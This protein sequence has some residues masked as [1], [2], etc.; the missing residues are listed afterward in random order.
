MSSDAYTFSAGIAAVI[1][2]SPAGNGETVTL[3]PPLEVTGG[4]IINTGYAPDGAVPSDIWV[5]DQD[6]AIRTWGAAISDVA[7][8]A[9]PGMKVSFKVSEIKN[10][11][12]ELEITQ[13]SDWVVDSEGEK[14]LVQ[15]L[16]DA[17][18]TY[19]S[20]GRQNAQLWGEIASEPEACGGSF[21]CYAI[22]PFCVWHSL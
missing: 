12:G 4:V 17:A 11:A 5:A 22:T 20:H 6:G 18:P 14:V 21:N 16:N 8:A 2:A 15:N 3:D 7:T 19:A 9:A 1:A 10:Y 13:I